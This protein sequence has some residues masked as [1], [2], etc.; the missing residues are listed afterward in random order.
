MNNDVYIAAVGQ[1]AVQEHW[2]HSLRELSAMAVRDLRQRFTFTR[3]DSLFVAN[4]FAPNLSNQA[5]LG[6]LIA[7]H[8]GWSGIEAVTIEA[9][10]AS[11]GSAIRQATLALKSGMVDSALVLGVEKFSDK[12][13]A[14]V[15]VALS[16]NLDA[17]FEGMQGLTPS[18]QA[19]LIA[20]LYFMKA[21]APENA[22][23]GFALN[24]HQN[25]AGNPYAMYQ[26]AITAEGY[27]K[28]EMINPPLNMF[29]IAP[30]ADGAAALLLVRGD[31]PLL[32]NVEAKVKISGSSVST[33][34]LALHDRRD[35]LEWKTVS[36]TT[37]AA[38]AAANLSL[39]DI[40]LFELHDQ[41]SV[42]L[43]IILEVIDYVAPG[44]G[45]KLGTE[46]WIGLNGLIPINTMGGLKARGFTGGASGVYQAVEAYNQLVGKAGNNQLT[47]PRHAL[48]Q[49]LGGPAS[50]AATH[51][52][53]LSN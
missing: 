44:E 12:I 8:L 19:A 48:I 13:G 9:G 14:D 34:T 29:D 20:R 37:R 11:G 16:T 21:K 25:G 5:H 33:D 32:N 7:E 49:C 50:T 43:P 31:D 17:D 18:A 26:K 42:Y 47:D 3:P 24:A 38:L 40:N 22:L 45:W 52:L 1:T 51:I 30:N 41:F 46:H 4:M 23:A 53:S 6:A 39:A 35:M 36:R 27:A 10:G 15:D 2:D 28:A